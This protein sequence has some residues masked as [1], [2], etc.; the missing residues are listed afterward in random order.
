MLQVSGSYDYIQHFNKAKNSEFKTFLGLLNGKLSIQQHNKTVSSEFVSSTELAKLSVD[1]RKG[2]YDYLAKSATNITTFWYI[3]CQQ[4]NVTSDFKLNYNFNRTNEYY[5]IQ[6]IIRASF[7]P[8]ST[9][10]AP[11]TTTTT[12]TSRT[13]INDSTQSLKKTDIGTN[14][15]SSVLLATATST[16]MISNKTLA[17]VENKTN[18]YICKT[19]IPPEPNQTYDGFFYRQ[20]QVKGV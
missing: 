8:P 11:L 19:S 15:T 12:T 4:V 7:D 16:L 13:P 17:I 5:T 2:D 10:V 9:T 1:L 6:A 20:V 18:P 3:D 14:E